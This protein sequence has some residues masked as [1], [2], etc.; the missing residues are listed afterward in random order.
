MTLQ[1][2]KQGE[3]EKVQNYYDRF[4]ELVKCLQTQVDEGF[5]LTYFGAGLLNIKCVTVLYG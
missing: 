2:I 3:W 4:I 1:N 5:K